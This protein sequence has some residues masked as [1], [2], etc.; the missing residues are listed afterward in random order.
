[1]S[2]V[3]S[4]ESCGLDISSDNMLF[5]MWTWKIGNS[6]SILPTIFPFCMFILFNRNAQIQLLQRYNIS[7]YLQS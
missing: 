7:K 3:Q 5:L 1:M 4:S 6:L 2:L